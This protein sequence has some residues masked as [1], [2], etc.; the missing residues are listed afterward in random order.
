MDQS[1]P[2][3]VVVTNAIE[4][5]SADEVWVTHGNAVGDRESILKYLVL[6]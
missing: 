6:L 2:T 1:G 5:L 4:E 3:P